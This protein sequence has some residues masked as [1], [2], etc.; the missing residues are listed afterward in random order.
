[1]LYYL[2]IATD[3][4]GSQC[5]GRNEICSLLSVT[6]P[7]ATKYIETLIEEGHVGEHKMPFAIGRGRGYKYQYW[8][9]PRGAAFLAAHGKR[10]KECYDLLIASK[11]E[12]AIKEA[13]RMSNN[14]K[15]KKVSGKQLSLFGDK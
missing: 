15:A 14:G 10:G 12:G 7:T 6:K 13:R 11:I 2:S 9:T 1:M 5:I 8:I 4:R 3:E